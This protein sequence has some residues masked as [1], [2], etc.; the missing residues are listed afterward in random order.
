MKIKDIYDETFKYLI[1]I[2]LRQVLVV[3]IFSKLN[4]VLHHYVLINTCEFLSTGSGQ[5]QGLLKQICV[6]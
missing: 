5:D 1:Q 2:P 4:F 3:A 6:T